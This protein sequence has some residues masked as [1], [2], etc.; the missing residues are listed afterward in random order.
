MTTLMS[1]MPREG[2]EEPLLR[3]IAKLERINAALMAHVERATDQHAGAYSLFQT[4]IM[5]E[6]R[7]RGRTEELTSLMHSLERSNEA[8]KAAKEEAENANRSKTKFL[9]AASHDLLQPLNAARLS[10][11]AL[12]GLPLSE[13]ARVIASQVERGLQT[14]E[15][16]IKT[17]L[18]ISKLDAGVVRPVKTSVRLRNVFAGIEHSFRPIAE[19]KNIRFIIRC[20]DCAVESDATLLQ[21][22][23][24]NLVSNAIRY[25]ERGGVLVAVRARRERCA[26]DIIDTGPGIPQAER[27]LVFEEFYRGK[28]TGASEAGLGLG[29]SIVR[30][31]VLALDHR[32]DDWSRVGHG[33]RFRVTLPFADGAVEEIAAG[34]DG[35]FSLADASVLVVEN[36]AATKTALTRLLRSWSLRVTAVSGIAEWR[37]AGV[38]R[39]P[40]LLIVD[41][42]LDNGAIG[43]DIIDEIRSAT[44]KPLPAIVVTADHSQAVEA[45]VLE[46]RCEL[47]HKPVKPARLRSLLSF[48]IL[49]AGTGT[50][51]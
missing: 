43:L 4:A 12:V 34:G 28:Q 5:L 2:R 14:I 17:L 30:R 37:A 46:A 35:E 3:R 1:D 21:R 45:L 29:L 8:L 50:D 47:I 27:N 32:L 22:V 16:V 42:H 13:E 11:S 15:D 20:P 33:S 9:A 41:Y 39:T 18:D 10:S 25:T 49:P 48:L 19:V 23:I 38:E 31:M 36:D 6:G 44:P 51:S 26:I 7:V 24:Q 40:D